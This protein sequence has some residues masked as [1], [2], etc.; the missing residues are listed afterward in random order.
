MISVKIFGCRAGENCKRT[1]NNI[2]DTGG[3]GEDFQ[4]EFRGAESAAW[5]H[6]ARI[7]LDRTLGTG[8]EKRDVSLQSRHFC[9]FAFMVASISDGECGKGKREGMTFPSGGI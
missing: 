5:I 8:H 9:I 2:F 4:D 3:V 6:C 1:A 7:A